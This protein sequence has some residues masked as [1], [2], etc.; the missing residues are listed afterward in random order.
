MSRQ[1]LAHKLVCS[2]S[3][4]CRHM[5]MDAISSTPPSGSA[6]GPALCRACQDKF[7]RPHTAGGRHPGRQKAPATC[8]DPPGRRETGTAS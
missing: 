5:L 6:P 8:C 2:K 7:A 1:A 4:T 3:A